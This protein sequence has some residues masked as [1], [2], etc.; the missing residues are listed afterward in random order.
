MSFPVP[1]NEIYTNE[2]GEPTGWGPAETTDDY[3]CDV[4]G[5][6]HGGECDDGT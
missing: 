5:F 3:W 1:G 6:S 4:C 2:A